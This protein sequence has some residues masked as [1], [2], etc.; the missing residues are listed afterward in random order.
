MKTNAIISALCAV[1]I[2]G[3]LCSNGEEQRSVVEPRPGTIPVQKVVYWSDVPGM[4][5]NWTT[6]VTNAPSFVQKSGDTMSGNLIIDTRSND[7]SVKVINS[8]SPRSPY[9]MLGVDKIT[10]GSSYGSFT[11]GFPS[12]S[13]T[14]ALTGDI[15]STNGFASKSWVNTHQWDWT[16][17]ITNAPA[18][19]TQSVTNGLAS[20]NDVLLTSCF[21]EWEITP[22]IVDNLGAIRIVE[23]PHGDPGMS[24]FTPYAGDAIIGDS[25]TAASDSLELSWTESTTAMIDIYAVRRP[26]VI[27]GTQTDKPLQPAGDYAIRSDI[28]STNGLATKSYVDSHQWTWASV[29]NKP[30]FATVATSGSYNDL[31][32]KPSFVS[33][34]KDPVFNDWTNRSVLVAG[35][36]AISTPNFNSTALGDNA[37]A[38]AGS[39]LAVG[40]N[41]TAQSNF[42]VAVGVYE[43]EASGG[44]STAVGSY[45]KAIGDAS[46]AIGSSTTASGNN[47]VAIGSSASATHTNSVSIG[48]NVSSHGYGTFN[49]N[50]HNGPDGFWIGETNLATYL[51]NAGS[52]EHTHSNLVNGTTQVIANQNGTASIVTS[53][54]EEKQNCMQIYIDHYG[55]DTFS[56]P[57]TIKHHNTEAEIRALEVGDPFDFTVIYD[58]VSYECHTTLADSDER[59]SS[60]IEGKPAW[61]NAVYVDPDCYVVILHQTNPFGQYGYIGDGDEVKTTYTYTSETSVSKTIATTDQ[62]SDFVDRSVT[63]GLASTSWVNNSL[64]G[65]MNKVGGAVAGNVAV[66]AGDGSVACSTISID[67]VALANHVHDS[68]TTD[69]PGVVGG[70]GATLEIND[71][72]TATVTWHPGSSPPPPGEPAPQSWTK[73]LAFTNDVQSVPSNVSAFNND[74]GYVKTNAVGSL[75]LGPFNANQASANY[76]IVAG[77]GG[78]NNESTDSIIVGPS[79]H[80]YQNS[81]YS[82]IFGPGANIRTGSPYSFVFGSSTIDVGKPNSFVIGCGATST[83]QASFLWSAVSTNEKQLPSAPTTHGDGTFNINTLDGVAGVYIGNTNLQQ[84]I[85]MEAKAMVR[86]AVSQVNVNLQSAEDTRAALTNLITILKNL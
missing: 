11:I 47:S 45:A 59:Y 74:A 14:F 58:G 63:N 81:P 33:V 82:G 19:V 22:A 2:I 48:A 53:G 7:A 12:K 4:K 23:T 52:G 13:G 41:V 17:Q 80:I 75:T 26:V 8:D 69:E 60:D 15:P 9:T 85:R 6:Q 38:Y 55:R 21:G 61:M 54:V 83:N 84:I 29:T 44:Y 37:K 20:T 50:P 57:L 86:D 77:S 18:F 65:K 73:V 31:N 68:I 71:D 32:N 76:T 67:D 36:G 51:A 28:P 46:V 62:L 42:D 27:L 5:W 34:E 30:S 66:L 24:N 43:T 70:S 39:T 25:W 78:A 10:V 1:G 35:R 49:V 56:K 40:N 16:T 79:S 72:G 64:S 3:A